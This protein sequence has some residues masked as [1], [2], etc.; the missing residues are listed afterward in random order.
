MSWLREISRLI[1]RMINAALSDV[2]THI[3]AQVVSYTAATNT[4]SIQP[5]INRIRSEDPNNLTTVAMPQVDDVPVKLFGSGKLV[6]AVP[7]VAGSYGIFHVSER[8]LET[9]MLQ[10]GQVDP[11]SSRKFSISDGWFDPGAYTMLPDG[12]NGLIVPPLPTDRIGLRTR[13]GTS[14][15]SLKN[16]GAI[17]VVAIAGTFALA[18][19][20]SFSFTG[21]AGSMSMNAA[22][23]LDVNGNLTV[24]V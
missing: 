13:L 7:P 24:L 1:R 6:C 3:P 22:G 5:C 10:G 19:D 18:V 12:D 21:P 4:C 15:I 11:K 16:D 9:C 14:E 17:E 2:H 23:L 8:E 20:G